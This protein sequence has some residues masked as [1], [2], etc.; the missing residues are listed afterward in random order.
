MRNKASMHRSL[1]LRD[2]QVEELQIHGI[3]GLFATLDQRTVA[4]G[5]AQERKKYRK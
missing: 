1:Y 2:R 3:S 5:A 4:A